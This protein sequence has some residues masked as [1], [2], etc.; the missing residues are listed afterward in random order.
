MAR[1]TR[2]TRLRPSVYLELESERD[3]RSSS[4]TQRE[5]L[6]DHL[7]QARQQRR[8]TVPLPCSRPC[9]WP[10]RPVTTCGNDATRPKPVARLT[11]KM[12]ATLQRSCRDPGRAH[13]LPRH[14]GPD[15]DDN[16]LAET[17][18][19]KQYCNNCRR[20]LPLSAC[21]APAKPA[22]HHWRE[23]FK[24]RKRTGARH[25]AV[26]PPQVAAETLRSPQGLCTPITRAGQMNVAHWRA[27]PEEWTAACCHRRL[28]SSDLQLEKPSGSPGMTTERKFYQDHRQGLRAR[29][30]AGATTPRHICHPR[31]PAFWLRAR[32]S[33]T[34]HH[35]ACRPSSTGST[36]APS[37]TSLVGRTTMKRPHG[38]LTHWEA[39]PQEKRGF[40]RYDLCSLRREELVVYLSE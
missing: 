19:V 4:T 26:W 8:S 37:W 1:T 35:A 20:R 40:H 10:D 18:V 17:A 2:G 34:A 11:Q 12:M 5:Y 15:R 7:V 21:K 32:T 22:S 13:Q 39:Q 9:R 38:P 33:C 14:D 6:S 24:I 30:R 31:R 25:P 3:H 23:N 29:P 27:T 28:A 16:E 36:A